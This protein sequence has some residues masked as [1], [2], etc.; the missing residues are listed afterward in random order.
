MTSGFVE[1]AGPARIHYRESGAGP[2]LVFLHGGW[3]YEIF[4]FDRQIE[5]LAGRRRIVIPDRS[6]YGRSPKIEFLPVDFHRRAAEETLRVLDALEIG[7]AALWGHSDGAV[8]AA[9]MGLAAPGRIPAVILEAMHY[10]PKYESHQWME[11][12]ARAPE[13]AGRR[14]MEA[15][16]RDHGEDWR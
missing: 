1:I 15:L 7:Q 14:A 4:P 16:A 13:V 3:G 12:M 9:I 10:E 11:T 5:A 6:G 8:I 2:P